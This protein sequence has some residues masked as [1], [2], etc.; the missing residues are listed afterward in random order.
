MDQDL[1]AQDFCPLHLASMAQAGTLNE[2]KPSSQ[3]VGKALWLTLLASL[4]AHATLLT[5]WTPQPAGVKAVSPDQNLRITLN[6]TMTEPAIAETVPEPPTVEEPITPEPTPPPDNTAAAEEII[7]DKPRI[8]IHALD[9]APHHP[10]TTTESGSGNVFHPGLRSRIRGARTRSER[11][12][13]TGKRDLRSWQDASGKTWVDLGDGTCM[14]SAGV[15][16]GTAKGWELPTRCK[17]QLT[18]GESMLRSM[19]RTL[20]RH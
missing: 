13:D 1:P 3:G 14:R 12:H 7:S 16:G 19:Q 10:P 11:L 17:E 4:L 6:T 18:E 9:I 8:D 15:T 2:E 5:L 20:D